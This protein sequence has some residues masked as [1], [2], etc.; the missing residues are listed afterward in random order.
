MIA[1]AVLLLA[2]HTLVYLALGA[3]PGRCVAG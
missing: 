3:V 1:M 2:L